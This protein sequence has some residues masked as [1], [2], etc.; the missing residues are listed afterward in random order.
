MQTVGQL[1]K[2]LRV[3]SPRLRVRLHRNGLAVGK[4]FLV[5]VEIEGSK[6]Q[7]YIAVHHHKYG[8]S[9]FPVRS[10]H[11]PLEEEVIN[12]WDIDFEPDK[13]EYICI[14]PSCEAIEIK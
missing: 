14:E 13:D 5:P 10:D 2:R 7:L 1:A 9:V 3:F 4:D 12:A 11:F 6:N 8:E